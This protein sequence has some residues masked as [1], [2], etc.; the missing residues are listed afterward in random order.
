[1]RESYRLQKKRLGDYLHENHKSIAVFFVFT[2]NELPGYENIYGKMG[3]ALK[4]LEKIF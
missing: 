3:E 1:M 2:G 4:K